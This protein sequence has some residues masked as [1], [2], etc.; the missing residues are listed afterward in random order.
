VTTTRGHTTGQPHDLAEGI[1]D[2]ADV[3]TELRDAGDEQVEVIP[4]VGTVQVDYRY[5][6]GHV[7]AGAVE[8]RLPTTVRDHMEVAV[9][10]ARI[11]ARVSPDLLSIHAAGVAHMA[12]YMTVATAQA[13][14]WARNDGGQVS[15][16][17]VPVEVLEAVFTEV[18]AHADKFR[19]ACADRAQKEVAPE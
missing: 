7:F 14:D 18:R 1:D 3:L 6:N 12:A 10:E 4:D 16:L 13:P 9:A 11:R 19:G 15:W 5:A 8:Y 2:P 17:G